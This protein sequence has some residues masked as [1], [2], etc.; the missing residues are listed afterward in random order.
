MG[1]ISGYLATLLLIV[2][3]PSGIK[4]EKKYHAKRK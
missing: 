2:I 4:H 3:C 1:V